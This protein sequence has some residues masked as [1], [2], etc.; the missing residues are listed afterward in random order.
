MKAFHE[1]RRYDSDFMV[2]HSA[3]ENISFLAHWHKEIELIYVRSGQCRLSVSD[4]NF[5]AK[6]GDFVVCESGG[7]DK[8]YISPISAATLR[9][10]IR[11][12]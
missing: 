4:Q 7:E 5:V 11:N 9:K 10:R 12:A 8:V 3:Y 1:V 2:W 6:S